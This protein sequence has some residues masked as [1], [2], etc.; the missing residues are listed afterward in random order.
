MT[1]ADGFSYRDG[2]LHC[3]PVRIADITRETGTPVWVYH[4]DSI[5]ARYHE[6][7]DA[8]A[9]LTHQTCY[10]V[11]ANS[12]LALL[13]MLARAGCGFDA[14]SRGELHRCLTA[15]ADPT[16][17]IMTGV[18]KSSADIAAALDAGI[19]YFNVES[20]SECRLISEL[21]TRRGVRAN[22]V[23]R[24]N[25]DI[26]TDTHPYISTGEASHKFGLN[27]A[28]IRTLAS[29]E[30]WL[31]GVRIAGLSFHLGSQLV[32]TDPYRDALRL[33][34]KVLDDITPLLPEAPDV[35][36]VGGGFGVPYAADESALS[37]ESLADVIRDVLGDRAASIQLITE[38]GRS[39]VANA[40]ALFCSVEHLKPSAPNRTFVILDAGMNDLMRPA[41][42][43]A[44]HAIIPVQRDEN[45]EPM[46]CDV[47]G[48]VCES[49]DVF[50]AGTE[51]PSSLQ[52]GQ[53][54]A[55]LS[56]GAYGSSMSSTYN[57]R[58][59]ATEVA[60]VGDAWTVI[61]ERQTLDD[62]LRGEKL[63]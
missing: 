29:Q 57:S 39:F 34:L 13:R 63:R 5:V 16:R 31:P 35:V 18:G 11:K 9:G 8:F 15:G 30:S 48:P 54:V 36:D 62:M 43:Q 23:L 47:V 33:L 51:L 50:V 20:A 17:I 52:R 46:L 40:G 25:P 21:A 38:P 55:I 10:A 41:L 7:R 27:P 56:A 49:S 42:Y 45:A 28:D 60:V 14:N 22:I 6:H 3:G 59:L 19:A 61:R 44:R 37:P 53:L 1:F 26:E 58:P 24:L 12:S 32:S 2:S 4:F